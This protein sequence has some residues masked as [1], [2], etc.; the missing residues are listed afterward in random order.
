MSYVI[1]FDIW[2]SLNY[3]LD[4]IFSASA[5]LKEE[6]IWSPENITQADT[7]M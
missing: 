4:Y 1:T 7:F 6:W 5:G 2:E 3:V